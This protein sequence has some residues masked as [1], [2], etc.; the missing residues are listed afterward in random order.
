MS[1]L[2]LRVALR[3]AR[4][5]AESALQHLV[6]D[7]ALL[8]VQI[9]RR[10]PFRARIAAGSALAAAGVRIPGAA[11]VG[12]LGAFMAGDVEHASH[13]AVESAARGSRLGAE[14]ALLMNRTDSIGAAAPVQVRARAAWAAGDLT[15]AV[16][17]LDEAGRGGS[18]YARR[19][20]S[21]LRLLQPGNRLMR[22]G[23]PDTARTPHRP[24]EGRP[25]RVLHLLTNSLPHTQSGYSLRSHRILRAQQEQGMEV[26]ALTRPGYPV[27]IGVPTARD[28]DVV[29]GVR[30]RRTL[31]WS[32]GT[33][34]EDRLHAQVQEAMRVVEEFRPQ[35]LHATTNYL[36]GLVAQ[37]V[38]TATGIPWV[39]EVRGFMEQTWAASRPTPEAWR[40]A[41]QSQ[42]LR[43]IAR[44]EAQLARE[45][46]AVV[47]LSGTM[48]REL[49][50]RGVPVESI[51]LVPNGVDE[52]LLTEH[53]TV[54]EARRKLHDRIPAPWEDA[55]LVG[56]VSALVHYE[57][58][59]T[60]LRAV[61]TVATDPSAPQALVSRLKVV[62]VGDGVALPELKHLA[63][64]LGIGD[65]VLMPGR[66]PIGKARMW[67]QALDAVVLPRLDLSVTRLVTPQKPVEAMAL[68]RPVIASDL[69]AIRD[70]MGTG[71]EAVG[72]LVQPGDAEGLAAALVRLFADR[73]GT[74]EFVAR[75]MALARTRTWSE[76]VR[77]YGEVYTRAA[78]RARVAAAVARDEGKW[79]V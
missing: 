68:G 61:A 62:L 48:A 11:G 66:V 50:A 14:T 30:Y 71:A 6:D 53:V 77:Q 43:L 57:G 19:L 65:R 13:R 17:L 37:A 18:L 76:L 26:L 8:V 78:D 2:G 56:A 15:E 34:Q 33:T 73:R 39:Y 9:S 67:V 59:D 55:V 41:A 31:P 52:S 36:N 49:V 3:N 44:R 22:T 32:L 20:R 58:F 72:V 23:R 46:H 7:P 47:T 1:A 35:V 29:D 64:R 54:R 75:G 27:M 70:V 40:K 69:P 42:K 5:L 10:L 45:A 63:D 51:T 25:L 79:Q 24:G 21:E 4:L 74:A 60:L 28:E 38:S 16:T 12:A